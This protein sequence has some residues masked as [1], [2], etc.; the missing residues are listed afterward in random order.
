M[1]LY[2][3]SPRILTHIRAAAGPDTKV[4]IIDQ[5]LPL[6]CE[7][8]A[9]ATFSKPLVPANSPLLPN[10]GKAGAVAYHADLLVCIISSLSRKLAGLTAVPFG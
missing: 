1:E 8:D 10:L 4:L 3:L 7:D 9:P 2:L 6:A 5:V